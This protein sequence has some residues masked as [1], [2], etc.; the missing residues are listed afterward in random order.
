MICCHCVLG[1]FV[2]AL[3]VANP[4]NATNAPIET[5][6][7]INTLLAVSNSIIPVTSTCQGNYG[8]KGKAAVKDLLAMQLAYLYSGNNVIEGNCSPKT[9]T[10]R[11]NHAS[12]E[13]VSS[14]TIEFEVKQGKAIA[15][16]LQC[17]ITP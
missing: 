17:V 13:D 12:G 6:N 5:R 14:A 10:I 2:A 9:C 4:V 7:A 1:F 3:L 11:I 16:T 8:Q 15:A